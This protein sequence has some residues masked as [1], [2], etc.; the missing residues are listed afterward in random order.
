MSNNKRSAEYE[1]RKQRSKS[2]SVENKAK[3][4]G[5][6]AQ[7][8]DVKVTLTDAADSRSDGHRRATTWRD[9]LRSEFACHTQRLTK[10]G[11]C[12]ILGEL[13]DYRSG[14]ALFPSGTTK[15]PKNVRNANVARVAALGADVDGKQSYRDAIAALQQQG[16]AF[17]GYSS[18]NHLAKEDGEGNPIEKF[19]IIIP[20][21]EPIELRKEDHRFYP[22]VVT[23]VLESLGIAF[24]QACRNEARVWFYPEHKPDLVA[25]DR[26]FIDLDHIDRPAFDVT[27][28]VARAKAEI[29]EKAKATKQKTPRKPRP[30]ASEVDLMQR[31]DDVITPWLVRFLSLC[32][33][34]FD[35]Q[36]FVL[37]VAGAHAQRTGTAAVDC[38]C[39]MRQT[40]ADHCKPGEVDRKTMFVFNAG[41]ADDQG[42]VRDQFFIGC[43]HGRCTGT[44]IAY[45]DAFIQENSANPASCEDLHTIAVTFVAESARKRYEENRQL[46]SGFWFKGSR[47]QSGSREDIFD[48]CARFEVS[49][50]VHDENGEGWGI[51]ISFS[52]PAG[53]RQTAI[54]RHA[55]LHAG[56]NSWRVALAERGFWMGTNPRQRNA[57][58]DLFNRLTTDRKIITFSRSGWHP[59]NEGRVHV[60]PLGTIV[61]DSDPN[62]VYRL[63]GCKGA[64]KVGGS[65]QSWQ[66]EVAAKIDDTLPHFG[67]CTMVGAAGALI[68][69]LGATPPIFY[70]LGPSSVG[71]TAAQICQA[72]VWSNPKERRLRTCLVDLNA[73]PNASEAILHELN[74]TT[75]AFDEVG[76]ADARLLRGLAFGFASGR[77]KDRLTKTIERRAS[78]TWHLTGTLSG[79]TTLSDTLAKHKMHV[80]EVA[81]EV[82]R[83]PTIDHSHLERTDPKKVDAIKSAACQ[84][85]GHLGPAFVN[86]LFEK[87]YVSEPE[88]LVLEHRVAARLK[89]LAP[90]AT[91]PRL[92]AAR[93][94]AIVWVTGD[95]LMEAELLAPTFDVEN[96]VRWAWSCFVDFDGAT[97][98][99][100]IQPAIET[101]I[102]QL[103]TRSDVLR[104]SGVPPQSDEMDSSRGLSQYASRQSPAIRVPFSGAKA[105]FDGEVYYIP[106]DF[107]TEFI[108]PTAPKAAVLKRLKERGALLPQGKNNLWRRIPE[109]ATEGEAK[110]LEHYR[111]T[112][113]K[114][115]ELTLTALE[116]RPMQPWIA[117]QGLSGEAHA[118]VSTCVS[119]LLARYTEPKFSR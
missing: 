63:D 64:T 62:A 72:S 3:I 109:K 108:G 93:S 54:I 43:N 11:K 60:S 58:A 59:T 5:A 114:L 32:G 110:V 12:V 92:R 2:I 37:A 102:T 10:E 67:F 99:D 78:Y 33:K 44:P 77:G 38:R 21:A 68:E 23:A 71:K 101:L 119:E 24:D 45:L 25:Q 117:L 73:T 7:W 18:F 86:V 55:H 90:D 83:M 118:R 52:N 53:Q 88:P 98:L 57:V 36:E 27:P 16:V 56:D 104:G 89:D 35:V 17:V 26:A 49:G 34:D 48:V 13:K 76:R 30:T 103:Q 107:I 42:A 105:Y 14:S 46:P 65:L 40:Y 81:G 85:Y 47:V 61:G 1:I 84:N 80:T 70:L 116:R 50:T 20:L 19:R 66:S 91:G 74:G 106:K 15:Q 22:A 112:A 69:I 29:E 115:F 96:C 51:E 100:P 97:K 82:V 94:F 6:T 8:L 39:S 4:S 111:I 9:W 87:G 95:I 79:E 28:F 113:A 75:I 31:S 41:S